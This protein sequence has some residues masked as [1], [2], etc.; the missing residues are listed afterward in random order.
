M[1]SRANGVQPVLFSQIWLTCPWACRG[2]P[3]PPGRFLWR[4][5]KQPLSWVLCIVSL[6]CWEPYQIEHGVQ[7]IRT[8]RGGGRT[9][10]SRSPAHFLLCQVHFHTP[11]PHSICFMSSEIFVLLCLYFFWMVFVKQKESAFSCIF[12]L[13]CNSNLMEKQHIFVVNVLYFCVEMCNVKMLNAEVFFMPNY[14]G[15]GNLVNIKQLA[16]Y[17]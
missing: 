13:G 5:G 15:D 14:F 10:S 11:P 16:F 12:P 9:C 6:V 4:Q 7:W 17:S 3:H 8:H 2:G 1:Y